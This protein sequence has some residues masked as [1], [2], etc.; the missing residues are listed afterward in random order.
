VEDR[1]TIGQL[2][3][4]TGVHV[5]TVRYYQRIGLMPLPPKRGGFRYYGERELDRLRFI[6]RA[7]RLGFSL[8]EIKAL[9]EIDPNDCAAIAHQAQE[10]KERIER[11]IE[12]LEAL[13]HN[14]EALLK[15]CQEG[16][17]SCPISQTLK[18]DAEL[19]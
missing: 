4:A 3:R 2:A 17:T 12:Q 15:A 11:E 18:T 7:K 14:L 9:L 1:L 6:K 5:E 10:L 19:L 8:K 16:R 13:R